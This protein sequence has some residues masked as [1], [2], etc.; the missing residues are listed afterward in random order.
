MTAC[1][2]NGCEA[3]ATCI[4]KLRIPATGYPIDTHQPLALAMGVALCDEHFETD[5][6]IELLAPIGVERGIRDVVTIM[7]RGKVPPDWDRAFVERLPRDS[8]EYRAINVLTSTG[9]LVDA[10]KEETS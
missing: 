4:P 3:E 10:D 8:D 2:H 5:A 7:T 1:C 6:T 9:S